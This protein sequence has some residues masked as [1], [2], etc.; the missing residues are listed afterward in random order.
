[1]GLIFHEPLVLAYA[2]DTLTHFTQY[3]NYVLLTRHKRLTVFFHFF[4]V[5]YS[6]FLACHRQINIAG[7]LSG[8]KECAF[9][10][11]SWEHW[12]SN[13]LPSTHTCLFRAKLCPLSNT[14]TITHTHT[15]TFV[16]SSLPLLRSQQKSVLCGYENFSK[17]PNCYKIEAMGN[18]PPYMVTFTEI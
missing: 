11:L 14:Q 10:F 3:G 2:P 8:A 17:I 7:D 12:Y 18:C 9:L 13:V 16:K 15:H 5:S 4:L 6:S 1:M